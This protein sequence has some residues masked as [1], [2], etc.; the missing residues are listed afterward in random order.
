MQFDTKGVD[1]KSWRLRFALQ[2]YRNWFVPQ[3]SMVLRGHVVLQFTIHRNGQITDIV[4]VQPSAIEAFNNA[5]Y[6]AIYASKAPPLPPE[7]PEDKIEP[8]TAI[9]YYNEELPN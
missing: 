5:A 4:I 7:Y 6:G 8:F 9:F 3:A 1:F 2:I